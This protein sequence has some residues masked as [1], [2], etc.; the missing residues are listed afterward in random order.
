MDI[1]CG[2]GALT[3]LIREKTKVSKVFGVDI[4]EKAARKAKKRGIKVIPLNIDEQDIP[5]TDNSFDIIFLGTKFGVGHLF[6]FWL[7]AG[8][9]RLFTHRAIRDLVKIYNFQVEKIYGFGINTELGLGKKFFLIAI[10]LNKIL[11][12]FPSFSLDL[13][14]VFRKKKL[15]VK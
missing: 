14:L 1:G 7:N 4:S 15:P 2:D 13:I 3:A 11:Q 10:F 9:L 12:A 8:H 5:F 6:P